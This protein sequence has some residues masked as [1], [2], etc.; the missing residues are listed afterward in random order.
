[1]H[2]PELAKAAELLIPASPLWTAAQSYLQHVAVNLH[3]RN[4]SAPLKQPYFKIPLNV[5]QNAECTHLSWRVT[6]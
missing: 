4:R 5:P 3:S 1:M 6:R 2:P